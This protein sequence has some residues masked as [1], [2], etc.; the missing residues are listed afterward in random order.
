MR[1]ALAGGAALLLAAAPAF[2]NE[3]EPVKL[4]NHELDQVTAGDGWADINATIDVM[5][6][7][8][9]LTVNANNIP[10]NAALAVQANLVGS[11]I[12]G[13]QVTAIQQV[14]QYSLP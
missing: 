7:D 14:E 11:A 2:A 8:I 10:V 13:A 3:S 12:Q 5:L 6:R 9:D 4:T 1:H